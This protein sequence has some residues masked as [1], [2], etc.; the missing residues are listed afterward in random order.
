M[1]PDV[2]PLHPDV[3]AGVELNSRHIVAIFE[4][5]NF[6]PREQKPLVV[7]RWR[8]PA[9]HLVV[10]I[11]HRAIQ[12]IVAQCRGHGGRESGDFRSDWRTW[13]DSGARAN[14][15][16]ETYRIGERVRDEIVPLRVGWWIR[17][18]ANEC[19][20]GPD[21]HQIAVDRQTRSAV[22]YGAEHEIGITR[23]HQ[24]VARRIDDLDLQRAVDRGDWWQIRI[25]RREWRTC[26][27][28][29]NRRAYYRY[30][31]RRRRGGRRAL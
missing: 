7:T 1:R 15:I 30:G 2:A 31:H 23:S 25:G 9:N 16:T 29:A 8:R 19:A 17:N 11:A 5:A 22:S 6:G 14:G 12:G 3:L 10:R 27:G 20:V 13:A 28:R 26:D 24:R 18:P 21:R 4:Q